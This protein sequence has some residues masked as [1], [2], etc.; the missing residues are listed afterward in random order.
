MPISAIRCCTKFSLR[1]ELFDLP[2]YAAIGQIPVFALLQNLQSLIDRS[3]AKNQEKTKFNEEN[4]LLASGT[5]SSNIRTS[6]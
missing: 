1:E 6:W 2:D 3:T 4:T 5:V